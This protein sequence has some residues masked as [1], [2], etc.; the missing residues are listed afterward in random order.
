[1]FLK[2]R[3]GFWPSL[4]WRFPEESVFNTSLSNRLFA[5]FPSI[6]LM[7]PTGWGLLT[8]WTHD[9]STDTK[10]WM[11]RVFTHVGMDI[12]ALLFGISV[13]GLLWAMFLPRW[14]GRSLSW[15]ANHFLQTLAVFLCVILAM[16]AFAYITLDAR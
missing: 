7:I 12:V 4:F 10:D 13:L 14:I 3:V 1:M 11:L 15:L 5:A 6:L 9:A 2:M 8:Y 16:L